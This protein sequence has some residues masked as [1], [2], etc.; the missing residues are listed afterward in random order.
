VPGAAAGSAA[1]ARRRKPLSP[2]SHLLTTIRKFCR[3][4]TEACLLITSLERL[5]TVQIVSA[6]QFG[7]DPS[8]GGQKVQTVQVV[9]KQ[10][11]GANFVVMTRSFDAVLSPGRADR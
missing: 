11:P 3:L 2:A 5:E 8:F 6:M 4:L 7:A 9:E 1:I 10:A